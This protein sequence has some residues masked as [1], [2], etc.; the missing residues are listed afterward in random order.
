MLTELQLLHPQNFW[1][2]PKGVKIRIR[3]PRGVAE[4]AELLT[5]SIVGGWIQREIPL[6]HP[7]CVQNLVRA[8]ERR[9]QQSEPVSVQRWKDV[10][11]YLLPSPAESFI[12][13]AQLLQSLAIS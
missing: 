10:T 6:D 8:L 3:H 4:R 7:Q 9:L 5:A 11:E 1:I 12:A 2:S 13:T